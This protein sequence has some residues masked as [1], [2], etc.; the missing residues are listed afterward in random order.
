VKHLAE[1]SRTCTA[2]NSPYFLPRGWNAIMSLSILSGPLPEWLTHAMLKGGCLPTLGRSGAALHDQFDCEP[3][4]QSDRAGEYRDAASHRAAQ[5]LS[6]RAGMSSKG[7]SLA[8]TAKL[9][10][11]RLLRMED[12]HLRR[13]AAAQQD[14]GTDGLDGP[15]T[16]Q[17][18]VASSSRFAEQLPPRTR[19]R[20]RHLFFRYG[21]RD[22]MTSAF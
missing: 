2:V 20:I 18:F 8:E 19:Q 21:N 5:A 11:R 16:G 12:C 6:M 10:C 9:C 4:A 14:G 3:P 13:R 15:M 17:M 1:K 7:G 22:A